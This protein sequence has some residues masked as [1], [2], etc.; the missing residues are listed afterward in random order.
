MQ[1]DLAANITDMDLT[2]RYRITFHYENRLE[3]T[4]GSATDF[5]TKILFLEG[6]ISKLNE[7]D[8]GTINLID[9][10]T[11]AVNVTSAAE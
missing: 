11:A 1:T 5:E 2:Y 6:I 10:R 8:T 4:F 3:I 7:T 9:L